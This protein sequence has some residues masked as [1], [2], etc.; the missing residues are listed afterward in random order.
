M[1]T[2]SSNTGAFLTSMIVYHMLRVHGILCTDI[3][4]IFGISCGFLNV[5]GCG[6]A[7]T[8]M[9]AKNKLFLFLNFVNLFSNK[10]N[11][12]FVKLSAK[13]LILICGFTMND[14]AQGLYFFQK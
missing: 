1:K 5:I 7:E 6:N 3:S 2:N 9:F 4:L 12:G 8:H 13:A 10:Y 14:D 11:F